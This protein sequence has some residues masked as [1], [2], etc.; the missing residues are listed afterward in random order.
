MSLAVLHLG[1]AWDLVGESCQKIQ[2]VS[3]IIRVFH[4]PYVGCQPQIY[5]ETL[6]LCFG[7]MFMDAISLFQASQK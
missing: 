1:I 5:I 7:L 3:C 6:T 2:Q 4:L